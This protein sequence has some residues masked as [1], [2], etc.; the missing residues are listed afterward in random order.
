MALPLALA[1]KIS[2]AHFA[3]FSL[4]IILFSYFNYLRFLCAL[5]GLAIQNHFHMHICSRGAR[6]RILDFVATCRKHQRPTRATITKTAGRTCWFSVGCH[7][8][9]SSRD[10]WDAAFIDCS[11]V[12]EKA[13]VRFRRHS[14]NLSL[15]EHPVSTKMSKM[16]WNWLFLL[17]TLKDCYFNG[18][19]GMISSYFNIADKYRTGTQQ[20]NIYLQ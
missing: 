8:R 17:N 19:F 12:D 20:S 16:F 6:R 7:R 3:P 5:A 14:L 9:P 4:Y 18:Y 1:A 15:T 2:T 13:L 11:G 10:Y